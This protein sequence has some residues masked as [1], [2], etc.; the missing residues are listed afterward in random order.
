MID[1]SPEPADHSADVALVERCVA[2]DAAAIAEVQALIEAGVPVALARS[3]VPRSWAD[4]VAQRVTARLLVASDEDPPRIARYAGR[5]PLRAWLRITSLRAGLDLMR[6][7]RQEE[8]LEERVLS[9][10]TGGDDPELQFLRQ[11]YTAQF[12]EALAVAMETLSSRDRRLLKLRILDD[13]NIDD[14]G[15]LHGVHR[16]TAARWLDAARVALGAGVRKHLERELKVGKDDLHSILRLIR[17]QLDL[18]LHRRLV[19]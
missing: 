19:D 8:T 3:R 11:H 5:G 15:A 14:I 17:S 9:A 10:G 16:A 13:L 7:Q 6:S 4:E 18:S 1:P 2:G 12:K